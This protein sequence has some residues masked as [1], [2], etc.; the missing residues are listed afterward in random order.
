[1]LSL[2][3]LQ[4]DACM[5]MLDNDKDGVVTQQEFTTAMAKWLGLN[6]PGGVPGIGSPGP[7]SGSGPLATAAA[8]VH[9]TKFFLQFDTV[10]DFGRQQVAILRRDRPELDHSVLMA[11]FPIYSK[12]QKLDFH[13]KVSAL[14]AGGRIRLLAALHSPDW[15]T[16][17]TAAKQVQQLLSIVEVFHEADERCDTMLCYAML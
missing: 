13:R 5:D 6:L 3:S 9:L 12:E 11:E 14:V 2:L 16:V 10:G 1:M 17:L 15:D 4:V 8:E 7:G